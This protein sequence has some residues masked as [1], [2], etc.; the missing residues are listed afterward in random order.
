MRSI[1]YIIPA[2]LLTILTGCT[3]TGPDCPVRDDV[4]V[5]W[6]ISPGGLG[7]MGYNDIIF[8]GISAAASRYDF[9]LYYYRPGSAEEIYPTVK[10]WISEPQAGCHRRHPLRS[11]VTGSG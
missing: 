8:G 11:A 2:I 5:H 10:Q 7:D 4:T 3:K 1:R 9:G 6:A